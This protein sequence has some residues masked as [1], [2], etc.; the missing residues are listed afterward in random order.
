MCEFLGHLDAPEPASDCVLHFNGGV[1]LVIVLHLFEE[2]VAVHQFRVHNLPLNLFL[3]QVASHVLLNHRGCGV[4][5]AS[6]YL[7]PELEKPNQSK[8]TL[9]LDGRSQ[10]QFRDH[11]KPLTTFVTAK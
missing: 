4:A 2:I 3:L 9:D 8:I 6:S 1:V 7:R 11:L 5:F 10:T